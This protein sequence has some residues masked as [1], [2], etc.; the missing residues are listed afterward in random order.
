MPSQFADPFLAL[1][2][3]KYTDWSLQ[4]LQFYRKKHKDREAVVNKQYF[5]SVTDQSFISL[6]QLDA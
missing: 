1:R 3:E 5:E 6:N 2:T 4:A